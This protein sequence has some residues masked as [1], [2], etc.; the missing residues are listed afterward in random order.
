M[1][2]SSLVMLTLPA[3]IHAVEN[4]WSAFPWVFGERLLPSLSA[5]P[6]PVSA[7]QLSS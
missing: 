7:P 5:S 1:S 2:L 4:L 3:H 6:A